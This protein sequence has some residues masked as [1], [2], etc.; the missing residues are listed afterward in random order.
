MKRRLRHE[1]PFLARVGLEEEAS[2]VKI[3]T[4]MKYFY[5]LQLKFKDKTVR[6]DTDGDLGKIF[7]HLVSIF[8]RF[9]KQKKIRIPNR[10]PLK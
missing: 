3:Y 5:P 2:Y 8:N 1:R 6:L 7:V 4:F 9:L 10:R